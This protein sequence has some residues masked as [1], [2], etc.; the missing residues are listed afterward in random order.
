MCDGVV[1][2]HFGYLQSH[3]VI[4]SSSLYHQLTPLHIYSP[5]IVQ[6]PSGTGVTPKKSRNPS[7][8]SLQLTV[9]QFERPPPKRWRSQL[10][11][12]L[13]LYSSQHCCYGHAP[14]FSS[15]RLTTML[16]PA[17]ILPVPL[18]GRD[19]PEAA[20]A[21]LNVDAFRV[22]RGF[23]LTRLSGDVNRCR[24]Q[25]MSSLDK[26]IVCAMGQ[27]YMIASGRVNGILLLLSATN[28]ASAG[29]LTWKTD[30]QCH[31]E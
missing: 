7:S 29:I 17:P 21:Q 4:I 1:R 8:I 13:S 23:S 6:T 30:Q 12:A 31:F 11:D 5:I 3:R 28:I 19:A 14:L 16:V 27:N 26:L 22:G 9:L 25:G 2:L 24:Q 15:G 10:G 20:R 18:T